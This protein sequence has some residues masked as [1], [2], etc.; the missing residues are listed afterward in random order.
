MILSHDDFKVRHDNDQIGTQID[1]NTNSRL[2]KSKTTR[3]A[4]KRANH[5]FDRDDILPEYLSEEEDKNAWLIV[6]LI[7]SGLW[8]T[9][10]LN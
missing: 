8:P 1:E 3:I 2:L 9:L 10:T 4:Y 5:Q 7:S 6:I